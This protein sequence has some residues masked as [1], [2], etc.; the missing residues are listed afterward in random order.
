MP[1]G[2]VNEVEGDPAPVLDRRRM[3]VGQTLPPPT[4]D[5]A[6]FFRVGLI[7]LDRAGGGIDADGAVLVLDVGADEAGFGSS[8]RQGWQR[9][10]PC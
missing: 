3:R 10:K 1:S 8:T 2:I 9:Q 6:G 4:R 7:G 5:P